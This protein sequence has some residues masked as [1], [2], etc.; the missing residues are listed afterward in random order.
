MGSQVGLILSSSCC[1]FVVFN[2]VP[3]LPRA[4]PGGLFM[5]L[6]LVFAKETI[7]DICS[8]H[9]SCWNV[10]DGLAGPGEFDRGFSDDIFLEAQSIQTFCFFSR[11]GFTFHVHL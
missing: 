11:F 2:V 6:S 4:L 8:K 10:L 1:L 9:L 7:V 3:R 5:W